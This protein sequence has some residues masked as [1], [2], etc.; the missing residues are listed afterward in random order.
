MRS[1]LLNSEAC[2]WVAERA[3]NQHVE[4]G[5]GSFAGGS[6]QVGAELGADE[7]ASAALGPRVRINFDVACFGADQ[8]ARPRAEGG[9]GESILAVRLLHAGG[10]QVLKDHGREVLLLPVVGLALRTIVDQFIILITPS[11]RCG[12][13]L[14]TVK[15]PA[16]R[17]I[18]RSW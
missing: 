14:S 10:P 16:T 8:I 13:R 3:G 4:V 11:V 17:T 15:G 12:A 2:A 1:S 5:V 18:Q 9:E 6:D 7:D